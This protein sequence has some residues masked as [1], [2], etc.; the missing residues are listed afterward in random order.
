M[1]RLAQN[2]ITII[3]TFAQVKATGHGDMEQRFL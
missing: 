3:Y 1:N 2:H